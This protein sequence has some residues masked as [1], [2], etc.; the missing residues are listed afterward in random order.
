MLK[1]TL[2]AAVVL[3]LSA[4]AVQADEVSGYLSGN[5][6]TRF[7]PKPLVSRAAFP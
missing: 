1:K 3:G 4:T 5:V 7:A 2:L 6:P